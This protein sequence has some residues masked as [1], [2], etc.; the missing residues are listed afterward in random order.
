MLEFLRSKARAAKDWAVSQA[1]D[2]FKQQAGGRMLNL[3]IDSKAR[4]LRLELGPKGEDRPIRI[5]AEG[6]EILDEPGATRIRLQGLSSDRDLYHLALR[7]FVEG[8]AFD[9]PES[10]AEWVKLM[11]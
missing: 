6:Y 9:V 7:Q 8:K 10:L 3:Q 11:L 2:H 5:E 1:I 4:T